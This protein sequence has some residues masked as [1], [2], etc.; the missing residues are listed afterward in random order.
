MGAT[1]VWLRQDLRLADNP[2]LR[3]AAALGAVIPLYILEPETAWPAGAASRVWLHHSLSALDGSLRRQ[4]SRLLLAVGEAA[5]VFQSL[6]RD[7]SI[8]RVFWNRRHEPSGNARDAALAQMLGAH[9]EVKSFPGTTLFEPGSV[10]TGEGRPYR[11]YTPFARACL[12]QAPPAPPLPVPPRIDAPER[13][14][15]GQTLEALRLLPAIDWA[16][17]IRER[18]GFGEDAAH[19]RLDR[20]LAGALCAYPTGRDALAEEGI[21]GMAPHLKQG[22]I[23]VRELWTLISAARA[24]DPALESGATAWLR[25]LLWREFAYHLLHH[26]P[27]TADRP[28]RPEFERMPWIDD[29]PALTAW[30]R[31][32]TGYPVVDAGM[33]ELWAT[34]YMHNRARMIVASFLCKHLGIHWIEGARWFWD[35]LVDADLANNTLGW[36]WT[37]GCGADAAPYFRIFNPVRQGLR[38]DPAGDY[39][40]RW[41][42]ELSSIPDKAVHTPPPGHGGYTLPI[43][44]L[45]VGRRQALE[46][47]D[48]MRAR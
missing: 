22:E 46:R 37:A 21:S 4:G 3:E 29:R 25:Q 17:G 10:L 45:A 14:P 30:C 2:A 38:F 5:E 9:A 7:P 39:V 43:C 48:E 6:L 40:R 8:N 1:I 32:R 31:G 18:W 34:G 41:V 42:P 23:S 28:L 44:D 15:E 27:H 36:Q 12:Q 16:G 47:F 33:R 13:W 19:D 26:F 20:F 24:A 11:V 35:T